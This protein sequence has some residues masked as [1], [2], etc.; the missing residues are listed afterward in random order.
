MADLYEEIVKLRKAGSQGALAT[1]VRHLGSTPRKDNAKM[2]IRDDGTTLGSVGGGCVEA[3]IWSKAQEVIRTGRA[4]LLSYTM[5]EEDAESDGLICGG[6]VEIFV[7]PIL[8]DPQLIIM[9]AGHLGQAIARLAGPLGFEVTVL[10]DR[11]NFASP[12]RFPD[13]ENIIVDSFESG[14]G[15]I[16]VQK[17]S[18]ILVVTRGHSHDQV[19]TETAIQTTARYVG[20]V[21]SRRK[22]KI[23]VENLLKKGIPP[24]SFQKLYAPIGIDIGSETPEEIAVSVMA[25]LIA[26]RKDRHQR[27]EKQRFVLDLLEQ[28]DK[29]D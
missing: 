12:E 3:E 29:A 22:I 24:E 2:L 28:A 1:I 10:D 21:G 13:V 9:G 14:L 4:A 18:F 16:C 20:L 27:S 15:Q 6:T 8:A 25:E 26:L 11:D 23:I 7:E 19:A 17:G 5:T